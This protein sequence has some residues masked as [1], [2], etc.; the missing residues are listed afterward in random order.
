MSSIY[1]TQK[2]AA[3]H[4]GLC[5]KYVDCCVNSC[6][7]YTGK[8]EALDCCPFPD[9]NKPRRDESGQSRKTFQYLPIIPCLIALFL[10]KTTAEKM[11]YQHEYC[12]TRGAENVTNIFDGTLYQELC[13]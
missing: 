4:S 13:K 11:G 7:C 2:T 5:P 8:Y 9:C 1:L 6:C 10:D 3:K 12:G